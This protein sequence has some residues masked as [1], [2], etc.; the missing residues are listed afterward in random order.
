MPFKK[1]YV[2]ILRA[3]RTKKLK[4]HLNPT[5]QMPLAAAPR[6]APKAYAIQPS[7]IGK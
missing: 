2:E 7:E 6:F 4:S 3:A 5:R 1:L